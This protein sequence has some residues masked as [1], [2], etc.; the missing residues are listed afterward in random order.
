M[1]I[2]STEGNRPAR[3]AW[4]GRRCAVAA[5]FGSGHELVV[6]L[7]PAEQMPTALRMTIARGGVQP[8]GS[9]L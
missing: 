6:A 3:T 5:R 2:W 7:L 4:A 8:P 9:V 1:R